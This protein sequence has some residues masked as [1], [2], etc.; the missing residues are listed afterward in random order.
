MATFLQGLMQTQ[1]NRL[2]LSV[3]QSYAWCER[4]ARRQAGNFYHAFRLLPAAKRR[5][6]CALYAFMRVADDLTDGPESIADKSVALENWRQ[7]LDA[8]LAGNYHHP[9]HP[10]FRHTVEQYGI[11]RRYLEDVLDGVGMD[12][13]TDHYET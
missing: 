13:D 10:A 6:M 7:Q 11:P 3:A 4:L 2:A 9:L 8:A 5:A 1:E 12:L